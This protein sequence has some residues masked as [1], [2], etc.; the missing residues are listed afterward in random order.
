MHGHQ[1]PPQVNSIAAINASDVPASRKLTGAA[2]HSHKKHPCNVCDTTLEDINTPKGYDIKNFKIRDNWAQLKHAHQSL[3]ASTER[4]RTKVLDD[5][6]SR[7]SL[8]NSLPG[9]LPVKNTPIDFM[10]NFYGTFLFIFLFNIQTNHGLGIVHSIFDVIVKGYLLNSAGWRQFEDAINSVIWP[11]GIGRLPNNLGGNHSLQKMY[12]WRR[13]CNIFPTI[14]WL[15]WKDDEDKIKQTPPPVP[16][17]TKSPPKFKCGLQI[18]YNAALYLSLAGCIF[19]YQSISSTDIERVHLTINHHLSMHYAPIFKRF[20]PA[21]S[22]WLFAFE[23]YNGELEQMNLNGHGGGEME[24]TLLRDWIEKN[25]LYE[26]VH[27]FS[28]IRLLTFYLI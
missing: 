13:L 25:R 21:Y 20:G 16:S 2:G 11:S 9:W 12:Q 4:A 28:I 14:L 6:G 26:M 27:H 24:Y 1:I 10:H 19:A 22:W 23:R 5:Y 7:Y 15:C 3:L 18:I 8:F 17:Q